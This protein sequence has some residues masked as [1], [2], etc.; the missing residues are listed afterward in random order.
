MLEKKK[1]KAAFSVRAAHEAD[2]QMIFFSLGRWRLLLSADMIFF[3]KKK[4]LGGIPSN[5]SL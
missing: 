5:F 1:K 4:G 3:G 2:F